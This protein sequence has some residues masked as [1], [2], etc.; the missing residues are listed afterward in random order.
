MKKIS[1]FAACSMAV[2]LLQTTGALAHWIDRVDVFIPAVA[3][4]E[5]F[6][7]SAT[8]SSG[9][10]TGGGYELD[11][12]LT[13]DGPMVVVKNR[14]TDS[15]TWTVELVNR[16][17]APTPNAVFTASAYIVCTEHGPVRR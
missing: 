4:G 13:S 14:P 12:R 3:G 1:K 10:V 8:C 2:F 5:T 15:R 11:R 7:V 17:S 16:S 6:S 9:H